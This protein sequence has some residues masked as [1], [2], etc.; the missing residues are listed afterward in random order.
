MITISWFEN[1]WRGVIFLDPYAMNLKW[2]SLEAISQTRVF[3][4]WYLFPLSALNRVLQ[5]DGKIPKK[6]KDKINELLGTSDWENE[7]YYESPQLSLFGEQ[8]LE[9]VSLEKIQRYVINRLKLLFPGVSEKSLVLR[10][11][12]NSP[13]FNLCFATN[14][15]KA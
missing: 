11:Y 6:N 9:R 10:N 1:Y 8:E 13:L 4:V 12:N 14:N 3:D 2:A 7:I 5:K 15:P